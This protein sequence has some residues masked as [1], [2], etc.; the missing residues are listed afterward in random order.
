[1]TGEA[2][3]TAIEVVVSLVVVVVVVAVKIDFL[4]ENLFVCSHWH[5]QPH[6]N[7]DQTDS[8]IIGFRSRH[9]EP[10]DSHFGYIQIP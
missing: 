7:Q 2:K 5:Q 4:R 9:F 3:A 8:R 6:H 10:F 1:M